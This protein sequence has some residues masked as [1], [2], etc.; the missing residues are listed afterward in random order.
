M[1]R[2]AVLAA[3]LVA[4]PA[5]AASV[6]VPAY[7]DALAYGGGHVLWATH[8][9]HGPVVVH[10]RLASGGPVTTL[11]SLPRVHLA[12]ADLEVALAADASGYLVGARDGRSVST[13]ECGCDYDVSQ[14]E[15]LVHGGWDGTPA[16]VSRCHP[17]KDTTNAQES[18][19]EVTAG[20]AGFAF[21]GLQCGHTGVNLIADDGVVVHVAG[22]KLP[23]AIDYGLAYA[24]PYLAVTEAAPN[25]ERAHVIDTAG[26]PERVLPTNQ[27]QSNFT[28]DV[29]ADGTLI[30]GT[31]GYAGAPNAIYLWAPG[32][33][34]AVTLP[35]VRLSDLG[36]FAIADG[37]I[38]YAP[39]KR[40]V[41]G[42]PGLGLIR[43]D[44]GGRTEVGAPGAGID[45]QVLAFDGTQAAFTS[46]S[47]D[48]HAQV[49]VVDVTQPP[50]PTDG[51]PVTVTHTGPLR[52]SRARHASVHVECPNGCRGRLELILDLSEHRV[53]RKE[54]NRYVDKVLDS[55]VAAGRLDGSGRVRLTLVRRARVLLHHHHHLR[56]VPDTVP[57]DIGAGPEVAGEETFTMRLR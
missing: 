9:P 47:C 35:H 54:L 32:A 34:K 24:E 36:T 17:S 42:R 40:T 28:F 6:R 23:D 4:A 56:V 2:L 19:L 55:H 1:R 12:S 21:G 45:R 3:L 51:C 13:G 25:G 41:K 16:D 43:D 27:Y 38:F 7:P 5:Q 10:Q 37:R 8:T 44:G 20:S 52:F 22:V 30:T 50:A 15:L 48:G 26:G 49:T 39:R 53:G 18:A 11:A 14:G 46:T 57:I 29:D 31:S 33:A